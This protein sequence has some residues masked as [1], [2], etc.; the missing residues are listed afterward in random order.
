[1]KRTKEYTWV[2]CILRRLRNSLA[3]LISTWDAFDLNHSVYFDLDADGNLQDHFREHFSFIRKSTAELGALH[4]ILDHRIETLEKMSSL[5]TAL[6]D[7]F[8][9]RLLIMEAGQRLC[10]R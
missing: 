6:F 4:M 2:L 7:H 8:A 3:K 9:W 1:M 10:A 5:V